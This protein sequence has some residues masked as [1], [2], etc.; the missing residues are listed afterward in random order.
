MRHN[1]LNGFFLILG[2]F[3][4]SSTLAA[5]VNSLL[6]NRLSNGIELAPFTVTAAPDPSYTVTSIDVGFRPGINCTG[7]GVYTANWYS[8]GSFTFNAGQSYS[9]SQASIIRSWQQITG[10][11]A[12]ACLL[13]VFH[14]GSATS[15]VLQMNV[16][17][18][19]ATCTY[20][21]PQ[22]NLNI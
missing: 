17:C 19:G 9:L 15:P 8:N 18:S 10:S 1:R 4:A 16:T 20:A 22:G 14:N 2:C 6:T 7:I 3:T 12:S 13:L 11:V 5:P 21:G